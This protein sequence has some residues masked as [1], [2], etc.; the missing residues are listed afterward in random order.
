MIRRP[1]RSTRTDPLFPYTT[2]FRSPRPRPSVPPHLRS[3]DH[4]HGGPGGDGAGLLHGH[5]PP[6]HRRGGR[7]LGRP[8]AVAAERPHAVDPA[9]HFRPALAG[10]PHAGAVDSR[11]GTGG[12]GIVPRVPPTPPGGDGRRR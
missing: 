1:P 2:L 8:V 12:A 11:R 5:H 6:L 9:A 10:R 4:H 3:A 7:R